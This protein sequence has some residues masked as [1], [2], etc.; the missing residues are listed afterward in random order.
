MSRNLRDAKADTKMLG[1]AADS[2]QPT[3]TMNADVVA[4]EPQPALPTSSE[5]LLDQEQDAA[6]TRDH[7][8]GGEG[9]ETSC[10][11]AVT[12][13]GELEV[14][15]D[16]MVHPLAS[17]FPLIVGEEFD[18]FVA[19]AER[20]GRLAAVE[21]HNGRLID[22]RNR[23]RVRDELRHRGVE[24][25]LPVVEWSPSGD[26]TVEEHI[27]SVNAHRRHLTADQRA[28]LCL[29]F[30]PVIQA[31]TRARQEASRFGAG[32]SPA[33]ANGN[34]LPAGTTPSSGRTSR[35][36]DAAS[37]VGQLCA[38]AD[39]GLHTGRQAMALARGIE[40][41]TIDPS[42]RAAVI[43]GDKRLRSVVRGTRTACREST[44][45]HEGE[46]YEPAD[47][48]HDEPAAT[49]EEVRR[50]WERLKNA[51]AITDHCEVR[52][53]L[54]AIIAEEQQQYDQ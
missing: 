23:V 9:S 40:N 10:E 30:L 12:E 6:G 20:A 15:G 1:E 50:R 53:L 48:L 44:Q 7:F 29:E 17:K 37:S 45:H 41:G 28:A 24:I 52:R 22:G 14:I 11:A 16:F 49:E 32:G 25:D 8:V 21:T 33:A 46:A 39:V 4:A 5:L 47:S 38:L 36:K 2:G 19:G 35:E 18:A 54:R 51:F 26:E 31:A 42:E 34:S 27:W 3:P 13:M 43:A